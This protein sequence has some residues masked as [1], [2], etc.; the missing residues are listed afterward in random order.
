MNVAADQYAVMGNPIGHSK[1]PA[2][3]AM[4][5]KQTGE[6]LR[7]E[8]LLVPT[9]EF[10]EAVEQ[11]YSNKGLGLNITVPFKQDAWNK[12]ER[13]TD[14]ARRAGAVNTLWKDETGA[15]WG[16]TTD[17]VGLVR[18]ITVN[19]KVDIEGRRVLVLGAGGAVRG[20]L[21]SILEKN[22]SAV[23]VANR[24]VSRAE[25]LVKLFGE[26][27]N[28]SACGFSEAEGPFDLIINGTSASLQGEC[29]PLPQT[30]INQQTTVY[31][32]MYGVE[33][34]VFNRW[35]RERG[36]Q[37]VIDGLGMLVEQAAE[38]FSIWRNK[39]P[40][41]AQVIAKFRGE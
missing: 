26:L 9:E 15:L 25:E 2:I 3:H 6:K 39:R 37:T 38:S 29:P 35:A 28:I 14:R 23:V 20:V 8:A 1:S 11:F 4:F 31:D 34:T 33:E 10:S 27:G 18:D 7:Y 5:A 41:T 12:A 13:M 22:P 16:D 36:A 17:G 30:A 19:H 21:E 32:M 40:E 24:T